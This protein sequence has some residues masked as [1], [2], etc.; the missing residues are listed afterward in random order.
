MAS[1]HSSRGALVLIGRGQTQT[2]KSSAREKGRE[3]QKK[4]RVLRPSVRM[5]STVRA[6]TNRTLAQQAISSSSSN[7]RA[8]QSKSRFA[9]LAL[10]PSTR[11]SVCA[12]YVLPTLLWLADGS[13][14]PS[15]RNS[16]MF[17]CPS[18]RVEQAN[19]NRS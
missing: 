18:C 2:N 6:S 3:K 4:G 1:V 14:L 10:R 9:F 13:P 17:P 5:K 19:Y 11:R 12:V 15:S 16:A 7:R 8:E